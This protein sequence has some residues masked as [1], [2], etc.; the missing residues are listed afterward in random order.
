METSFEEGN[1]TNLA[2]KVT[3]LSSKFFK[4]LFNEFLPKGVR[5]IK[6]QRETQIST[7]ERAYGASNNF[8][9]FVLS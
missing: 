6:P 8:N 7:R 4:K 1:F 2:Q 5:S 3:F 9:N